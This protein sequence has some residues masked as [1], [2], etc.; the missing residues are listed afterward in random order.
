MNG[1]YLKIKRTHERHKGKRI[2]LSICS[3][4]NY[5]ITCG[6]KK[7]YLNIRP[8]AKFVDAFI[9]LDLFEITNL[10]YFLFA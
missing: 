7:N 4:L 6:R 10:S 1:V 9:A 8:F 3:V 5:N 2:S